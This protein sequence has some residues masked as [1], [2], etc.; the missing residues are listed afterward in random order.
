MAAINQTYP[1]TS[2]PQV[3]P[4][5]PLLSVR[6]LSVRLNGFSLGPLS[7]DLHPGQ[8]T[9]LL[10]HNGAGKTTTMRLLVGLM[11]KDSGS[12]SLGSLRQEDEIAFRKRIAFV[13]EEAF[14]YRQ[15]R[16]GELVR[17]TSSFYSDWDSPRAEILRDRLALD[18]SQPIRHLSKGTRMKLSLLL[19]LARDPNV[20]LLDEPTS[21]LDP[22]SRAEVLKTIR[23]AASS[24]KTVLLS[25]HNLGEA[26]QIADRLLIVDH[27]RVL[28]DESIAAIR[29]ST[30]SASSLESY[31]LRLVQ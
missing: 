29:Q 2:S 4:G 25:T 7:F 17:F 1:K 23:A 27:G 12:V 31:Y 8:V 16:V 6:D 15:M 22:R 21:G 24:N 14:F 9:V 10:G 5:A 30:D 26:E 20:L 11:R 13:P 28:A 19:A 18:Y 3:Q